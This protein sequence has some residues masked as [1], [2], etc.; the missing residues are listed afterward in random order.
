[1]PVEIALSALDEALLEGAHGEAAREAMAMLVDYARMVGAQSFLDV[2]SAHIDGCLL[3]GQ[4]S[5]DFVDR[6]VA[7]KG[8]VRVVTTL[9]VASIDALHP[10]LNRAS[11]REVEDAR[12]L[13]KAYLALGARATWTCAP[14]QLQERPAF[15]RHIAWAE[16]NAVVFA[17]SV[18]GARTARYGDFV[19]LLIAL[20]G[21]APAAGLHLDEA[22]TPRRIIDVRA[23]T[24][25]F[26]RTKIA[27]PV[28][29]HL[30]GECVG[31]DV[32]AI[33]G[34]P[35][36]TTTEDDLKALGA[37]AASS[38]A[39]ALFHAVGLTP[40]APSESALLKNNSL[41]RH[42]VSLEDM[43][44][45]RWSLGRAA[46]GAPIRAISL[47]TP[48]FSLREFEALAPLLSNQKRH[49]DVAFFISTSRFVLAQA[50]AKGIVRILEAFGATIIV[51]TCTYVSATLPPG[52]GL[53]LTNSGK[54][55]HYA[56]G[57]LGLNAMLVD[58]STCVASAVSGVLED[59]CAF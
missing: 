14:Y 33:I 55:A 47:G 27:Y 41:T 16:S 36:D 21:R 6:F 34:L 28:L 52:E 12:A 2:D 54:W 13:M 42:V 4:A 8:K 39:V 40:E 35:Q 5:L 30:I 15:G 32:P 20:T 57:N 58:L 9:N 59:D 38:G 37:A 25:L 23:C 26:N 29:G 51:D 44:E 11:A 22:R 48:H 45:K 19:D 46:P 7:L 49:R 43:R 1:L 31:D 50:Q 53:V 18:L 56:P 3:H 17:N 10:E 24:A